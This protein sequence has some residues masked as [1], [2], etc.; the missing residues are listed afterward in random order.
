M[1]IVF[2]YDLKKATEIDRNRLQSMFLRFGWENVGGSCYRYPPLPRVTKSKQNTSPVREDWLNN[3]VPAIMCFRA[4][5]MKRG[6]KLTKHSIDIQTSSGSH[7]A[8]PRTGAKVEL[9]DPHQKSFGE[10]N[11]RSWLDGVTG[12]IPY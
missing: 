1:P 5:I 2:S 10:K 7:G 8:Q 11:L 6:I 4:F 9:E 3:V 12:A